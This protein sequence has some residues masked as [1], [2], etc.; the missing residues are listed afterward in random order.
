M[1]LAQKNMITHNM[2]V[3]SLLTYA[4]LTINKSLQKACDFKTSKVHSL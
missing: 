1:F 4:Q 2:T 3:T